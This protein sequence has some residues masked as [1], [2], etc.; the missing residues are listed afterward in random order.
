MIEDISKF[1][2]L[3]DRLEEEDRELSFA[4]QQI[5][6]VIWSMDFR[7]ETIHAISQQ[8]IAVTGH[9]D[10][11]FLGIP[12]AWFERIDVNHLT[13]FR[14]ACESATQ[15]QACNIEYRFVRAD[16]QWVWLRSMIQRHPDP[17]K[18]DY[19]V[20]L[21][22]D[23]T[24][25]KEGE[26][27]RLDALRNIAGGIAHVVN[28]ALTVVMGNMEILKQ[29]DI[30]PESVLAI[31]QT[32]ETSER[33]A[34][35]VEQLLQTAGAIRLSPRLCKLKDLLT[36]YRATLQDVVGSQVELRMRL[37]DSYLCN[38]DE[39]AFRLALERLCENAKQA[40]PEGGLISIETREFS[41]VAETDA[42]FVTNGPIVELLVT[43]NG[44]GMSKEVVSR[45]LQ[46]F[47]STRHKAEALGLGLSSVDGF[48]RQSGGRLKIQSNSE[49]GTTI[50]IQFPAF[51]NA[52]SR[53][54]HENLAPQ[55]PKVVALYAGN[56]ALSEV[57]HA[58]LKHLGYSVREVGSFS[59][60]QQETEH[61]QIAL[62]M[63][64]DE[65]LDLQRSALRS[66]QTSRSDRSVVLMVDDLEFARE[67]YSIPPHWRLIEKPFSLE[68]IAACLS[69]L[70]RLP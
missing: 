50:L 68:Q 16:N 32:L 37:N 29:S 34:S 18:S 7:S 20:A 42:N 53:V 35:V 52:V 38:I 2:Q 57:L 66:L 40:V 49:Q 58:I 55:V 19:I 1:V 62:V 23:I 54:P 43:D 3:T 9:R 65:T 13:A 48:V 41:N 10:L 61:A 31:N 64:P 26:A 15:R 67:N 33:T 6:A 22:L 27:K 46:P 56:V 21:T 44:V 51:P 39:Q 59:E 70:D 4:S 11:A 63:L 30:P 60:I 24:R 25:D 69:E 36:R 47:F 5:D 45:A 12:G 8:A 14:N 28:N 17:K